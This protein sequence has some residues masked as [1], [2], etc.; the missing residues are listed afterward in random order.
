MNFTRVFLDNLFNLQ[1]F[2]EKHTEK[3][4]EE[5]IEKKSNEKEENLK[6][7]EQLNKEVVKVLKQ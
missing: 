7:I 4:I 3:H 5:V 2:F 6:F 1:M